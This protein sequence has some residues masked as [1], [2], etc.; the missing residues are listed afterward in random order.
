MIDKKT[1]LLDSF[2]F[3]DDVLKSGVAGISELITVPGLVNVDY[4]DVKAIM[5]NTG[6]ALMGIG[7]ASGDNRAQEAAKAA[8]ESPL[9]DLSIEGARGI[10]FIVTGGPNL[11]LHEVNEA[12]K[13][14]TGSAD[15]SAKIIFGAVIDESLKDEIRITVVATGFSQ[16]TFP[17]HTTPEPESKNIKTIKDIFS[18]SQEDHASQDIETVQSG[19]R[20]PK[21]LKKNTEV[22]S[23][24]ADEDEEELEIPAFI[25]KKMNEKK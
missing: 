25:R 10:L 21:N 20:L 12:A 18:P 14:I 19:Y 17:I 16:D 1:S 3:V 22:V 13:I 24:T 7:S 9:L 15:E 8:I 6:S 23:E 4:A 2:G 11:T 5:Q